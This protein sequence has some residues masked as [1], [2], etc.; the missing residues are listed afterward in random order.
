MR[1]DSP[2]RST[3]A[4][5]GDVGVR[6]GGWSTGATVTLGGL[7]AIAVAAV[8]VLARGARNYAEAG[9]TYPGRPTSVAAAVLRL[10][11]DVAGAVT[12]GAL[13]FAALCTVPRAAGRIG[14]DGYSALAPARWA[15]PCWFVLA[16]V[17]TPVSAAD[18]VGQPLSQ[19]FA[20][21]HLWSV[22]GQTLPSRAWLVTAVCVLP[23]AFAVRSILT[24]GGVL[25]AA[26]WGGLALLPP[27]VVGNAG[28]GLGHDVDTTAAILHVLAA[29]IW[30]GAT[31][32]ALAHARRRGDR[33]GDLPGAAGS[34]AVFRRLGWLMLGCAGALAVSGIAL[35][36]N[37]VGPGQWFGTQYG[38]LAVGKAVALL[39]LVAVAVWATRRW[40]SWIARGTPQRAAAVLGAQLAV[41]LVLFGA[42]VAMAQQPAAGFFVTDPTPSQQQ[43]G[44]SLPR[45]PGLWTLLVT[46]R[47]DLVLGTVSV[48][49]AALYVAGV[50]RVRR[51]G[52]RWPAGRTVLFLSGCA[53]L[54]LL[55]SSGI[56][57]Y[58]EA[59]F[60]MHMVAH[61]G[62]NMV[63]PVLL[64]LGAPRTL[65]D[66]A[67]G[68]ADD[69]ALP[70]LRDISDR[71]ADSW[72]VRL[73]TNPFGA[74]AVFAALLFGL[75]LTPIFG[76]AVGYHWGHELMTIAFLV[77]GYF[78]FWQIIGTDR[79]PRPA[80]FLARLGLLIAL[81]PIHALFGVAILTRPSQMGLVFYGYLYLPW[82]RDALADQRVGA[83]IVWIGGELP[84]IATAILVMTQW[85]RAGD[86]IPAAVPRQDPVA[87]LHD[88]FRAQRR[89]E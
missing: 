30:L 10:A 3:T 48:V 83:L 35:G 16:L 82:M 86:S 63:V 29:A 50:L 4:D 42:S 66:V 21:G 69:P 81:M 12:V 31:A 39:V 9:F 26:V 38:L 20:S 55:T 25:G 46:W 49:L 68:P 2:D 37:L 75:Y 17:E 73:L 53:A 5:G 58:A 52:G 28:E 34:G 79:L 13:V 89:G 62:V 27:A 72:P 1:I 11:A 80:P 59:T 19:L 47:F 61:M 51:A 60:S 56:A 77:S 71:V 43:I 57:A 78:L 14:V 65:L 45:P 84:L 6:S 87:A 40:A 22:I 88:E 41:L 44:Y 76:Y 33:H 67:T 7:V 70:R 64:V 32:A 54:L 24:V 15:A 85:W 36:A 23:L 18:I 8:A 74:V